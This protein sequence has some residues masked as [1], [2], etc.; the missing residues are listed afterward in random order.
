MR[1][2]DRE[3]K[4]R[5]RRE[6]EVTNLADGVGSCNELGVVVIYEGFPVTV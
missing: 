3:Q 6:E 4:L 2:R 5:W 1:S